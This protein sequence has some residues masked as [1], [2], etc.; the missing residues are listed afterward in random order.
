MHLFV[1]TVDAFNGFCWMI[2]A[3]GLFNADKFGVVPAFRMINNRL[4]GCVS[5]DVCHLVLSLSKDTRSGTKA[6]NSGEMT[7]KIP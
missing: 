5:L 2:H 3:H 4:V 7:G 1:D 6:T